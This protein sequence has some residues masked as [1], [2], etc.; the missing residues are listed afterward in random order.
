MELE[1]TPPSTGTTDRRAR[2]HEL[3][4]VLH[5]GLNRRRVLAELDEMFRSGS[6]PDPV[7]DGFLPGRLLATSTWGPWDGLVQRIARAWM[8]W[9]GKS[10][11]PATATGRNRLT[12]TRGS[13]TVL[14]ALWPGYKPITDSLERIEAFEFRN[15]V[16]EG[17][18]DPGLKVYKIDYDFEANPRFIIRRILDELVEVADGVYLGK[19]LFRIGSRFHTIGFFLLER[20]HGQGATGSLPTAG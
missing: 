6:P 19:V 9:M 12:P 7:P 14:R 13:R 2:L 3:S 11:G 18:V 10:F 1:T 15:R 20:P 4:E 17:A 8:P 5:P 16:A